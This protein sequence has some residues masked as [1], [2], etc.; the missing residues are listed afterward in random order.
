MKNHLIIDSKDRCC[1]CSACFNICPS[2]A[3]T[4]REDLL[5]F[6]YPYIDNSICIGCSKCVDVCTFSVPHSHENNSEPTIYAAFAKDS[7][8]LI[9]SSSGGVFSIIA[10]EIIATGG[11]VYGAAWDENNNLSHIC[12]ETKDGVALLNGSK[13]VQSKIG[14]TFAEIEKQLKEGIKVCFSGTPCQVNGLKSYLGK[15]YPGLITVDIVCHGV[16]SQKMLTDD[17]NSL[18]ENAEIS[19]LQ[20]RDKKYGWGT[21]GSVKQ[22][23]TLE[24]YNALTSPFYFYFLNGELYRDSCY[25]CRFPSEK[26]QGDITLGDY[27]GVTAQDMRDLGIFEPNQGLSCVLVNTNKGK[28]LFESFERYLQFK[29]ITINDAQRRNGQLVHSSIKPLG[30]D[31]L[32]NDY[33]NEGWQAIINHYHKEYKKRLWFLFKSAIPKEFKTKLKSIY[34]L[35]KRERQ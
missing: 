31:Q 19:C 29:T 28:V 27:W 11:F 8:V 22:N 33:I 34:S 12:I 32:I 2:K 15:D 17:L 26:R 3:I 13:Y 7:N 5:G 6:E 1:G 10:S 20:F 21:S 25:N 16:P 24:K 23:G 9:R 4:M 14:S 30:H 35:V 18:F